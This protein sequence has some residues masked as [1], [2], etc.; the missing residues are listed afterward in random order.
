MDFINASLRE[1]LGASEESNIAEAAN[2]I[3]RK[4]FAELTAS[5]IREL[6]NLNPELSD[7]YGAGG[8]RRS[9]FDALEEKRLEL[10]RQGLVGESGFESAE[11]TNVSRTETVSEGDSNREVTTTTREPVGIV[12]VG[13][14]QIVPYGTDITYT[15]ADGTQKTITLNRDAIG[16][17]K[18]VAIENGIPIF[19]LGAGSAGRFDYQDYVAHGRRYNILD[20]TQPNTFLEGSSKIRPINRISDG[21]VW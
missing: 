19:D 17:N 20:L 11:T 14:G 16:A 7:A 4:G 10:Q 5:T 15:E 8:Y 3:N 2:I 21:N 13:T 9:S 18:I 6:E 1:E 12:D